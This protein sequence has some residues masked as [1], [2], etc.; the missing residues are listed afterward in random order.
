MLGI[1]DISG[2]SLAGH[3]SVIERDFFSWLGDDTSSSMAHPYC[4]VLLVHRPPP[5]SRRF[6]L[7]GRICS[8]CHALSVFACFGFWDFPHPLGAPVDGFRGCTACT[9]AETPLSPVSGFTAVGLSCLD[10]PGLL[11]PA[12]IHHAWRGLTA[13]TPA[14]S[15]SARVTSS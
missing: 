4:T 5:W 8:W 3:L 13:C 11:L 2:A 6:A 10:Q 12:V 14:I 9:A 15:H 7:H 1:K